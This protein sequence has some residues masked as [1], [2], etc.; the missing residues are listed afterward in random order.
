M[1]RNRKF[2][3]VILFS[4]LFLVIVIFG[5]FI[6]ASD[7]YVTPILMYHHINGVAYLEL[8]SVSPQSF[9]QQMAYLK[10]HKYN[11]IRLDE[12]VKAINQGKK[13]PR[14]TA[15]LTFD[16]GYDDNY[17]YAF[18]ILKKYGFP[19]VFFIPTDLINT[20]GFMT[21]DQLK[22]MAE[23]GMEIGSH[24][25]AHIYLPTYPSFDRVKDEI[26][27]S[28]KVLEE[29]LGI[30]INYFCYPS[31]GF[32][33]EI[34]NLLKEAGYKGACTTNRGSNRFNKDVYELKRIRMKDNNT[35]SFDLWAKT[36]GY[37]NL[38]RKIKQSFFR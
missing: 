6:W 2:K 32:D 12:L 28:K 20:H 37:Y 21:W 17:T 36:S 5:F 23:D 30:K 25:R 31:G 22:V 38:F 35:N 27:G 16:D 26:A 18:P 34:K 19:A 15:V 33:E 3:R 24:T 4:V 10:N 1:K 8:T 7:K 9:D 14:K 11:V 13:L 29:R